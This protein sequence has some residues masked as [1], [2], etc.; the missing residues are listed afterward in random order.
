VSAHI[1]RVDSLEYLVVDDVTTA[2]QALIA[3]AA[4][5]EVSG[6]PLHAIFSITTDRPDMDARPVSDGVFVVSGYPERIFLPVTVNI[7]IA[8]P[9]YRSVSFPVAIAPGSLPVNAASVVLRPFP[10]RV[11]GRV[12][13]NNADRTPIAGATIASATPGALALRTPVHFDHAAGVVVR[14]RA[15]PAAGAPLSLSEPAAGQSRSILLNSTAGLGPGSVLRLGEDIDS[16]YT[17][18]SALGPDAGEVQ[19]TSPLRRSFDLLAA[20]QPVSPGATGASTTITRPADS[21]D[22]LLLLGASLAP[23]SY[24]IADGAATEYA[25]A[26]ALTDAAGFFRLD[27]IVALRI[28]DL[29]ASAAGFIDLTIP[30][31]LDFAEPVTVASFRLST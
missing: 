26:N 8:A 9:G 21:G 19:L 10:V 31:S 3:A 7:T 13:R 4:I 2:Y 17:V 18:V 6:E 12:T 22:G 1:V 14:E 28:L 27:G 5:D 24:E 15:L 20:V 16:E 23:G 25:D 11:Q 30:V 29:R